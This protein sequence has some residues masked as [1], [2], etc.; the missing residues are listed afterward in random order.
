MLSV[1]AI[2]TVKPGL[3]L[4]PSIIYPGLSTVYGGVKI[5]LSTSRLT[6]SK[7]DGYVSFS[8]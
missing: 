7:K 1:E 6:A 8:D 5:E 4:H 2:I 3:E